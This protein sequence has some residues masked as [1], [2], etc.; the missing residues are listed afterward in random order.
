MTTSALFR[1]VSLVMFGTAVAQLSWFAF[2]PVLTRLY[3]PEEFGVFALFTSL[4]GAVS[5][6][7]TGR[8]EVAAL[9]SPC[10][11]STSKLI[12]IAFLFG[13]VTSAILALV[14]PVN[15]VNFEFLLLDSISTN[16]ALQSAILFFTFYSVVAVTIL[17]AY[18]N[19]VSDALCLSASA[20]IQV[21]FSIIVAISVGA[22]GGPINGLILGS[23][24]GTCSA[25]IFILIRKTAGLSVFLREKINSD[26]IVELKVKAP[27][28]FWNTVSA[29]VDNVTQVLPIFFLSSFMGGEMLGV[30]ALATRIAW[31]P[32]AVV[33]A[34]LSPALM[35]AIAKSLKHGRS[36][37]LAIFSVA[38]KLAMLAVPFGVLAFFFA[39]PIFAWFFGESWRL[40]GVILAIL[41]PAFVLRFIGGSLSGCMISLG[42]NDLWTAWQFGSFV[43]T[44]VGLWCWGH[45]VTGLE[46]FQVLLILD[47]L[48]YTSCLGLVWLAIKHPKVA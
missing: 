2:T 48:I 11:L 46:I 16:P 38:G 20:I 47:S 24:A 26:L 45:A 42:R 7:L 17:K 28:A 36:P 12:S 21:G 34:A 14:I 23:I 5:P 37:A 4:I 32:S 40:T 44:A 9:V 39:E 41:A 30:Y 22:L 13:A 31:A 19:C 35:V 43:T 33:A 3:S 8:F 6:I 29:T 18:C 1:N 25:A 10:S 27:F 15:I